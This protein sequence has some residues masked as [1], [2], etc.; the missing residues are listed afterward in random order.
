MMT[1]KTQFGDMTITDNNQTIV[2][3][4]LKKEIEKECIDNKTPELVINDKQNVDK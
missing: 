1:M 2:T 3:D 4:E